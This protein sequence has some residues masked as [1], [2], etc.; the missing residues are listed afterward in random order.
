MCTSTTGQEKKT[1]ELDMTQLMQEA[2]CTVHKKMVF[3]I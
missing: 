2:W 1:A 3:M